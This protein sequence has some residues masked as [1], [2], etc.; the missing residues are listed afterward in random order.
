M[1]SV[2]TVSKIIARHQEENGSRDDTYTD[3]NA[4]NTE[5]PETM[6]AAYQVTATQEIDPV[7]SSTSSCDAPECKSDAEK[8][9]QDDPDTEG[10]K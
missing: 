6:S 7:N 5:D 2:L 10:I 3:K 1:Y 4:Q 8:D 9:D